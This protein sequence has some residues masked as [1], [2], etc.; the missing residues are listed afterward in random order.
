MF[1][2]FGMLEPQIYQQMKNNVL[3][4]FVIFFAVVACLLIIDDVSYNISGKK[5]RY[6]KSSKPVTAN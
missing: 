6:I 5:I 2:S 3:S 4:A 1:C